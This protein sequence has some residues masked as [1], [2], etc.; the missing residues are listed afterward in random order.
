[1]GQPGCATG[2]ARLRVISTGEGRQHATSD[3]RVFMPGD[4]SSGAAMSSFVDALFENS[5]G[6]I[7]AIEVT[8][9]ARADLFPAGYNKW[10]KTIGCRVTAPAAAGKANHA[11]IVLIGVVLGVPVSSI[12]IVAGTSSSQ[13]KVSLK[14]ISKMRVMEQLC[15]FKDKNCPE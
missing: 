8:A 3:P 11:V 6:T 15:T 9:G 10:R 5:A 4:I 14:G 12:T 13:K 2:I 1:M 7:M